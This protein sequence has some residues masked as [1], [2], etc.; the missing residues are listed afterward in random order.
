[1]VGRGAA[2]GEGERLWAWVLEQESVGTGGCTGRVG[3]WDATAE[4][5]LVAGCM[6]QNWEL[7][8]GF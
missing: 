6:V 2:D 4:C 5:P 7:R 8:P 1:M 3:P